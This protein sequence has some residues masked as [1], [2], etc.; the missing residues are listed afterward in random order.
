MAKS[1]EY[2]RVGRERKRKGKNLE[3]EKE[4]KGKKINNYKTK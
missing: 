3:R 2:G 4:K 1:L